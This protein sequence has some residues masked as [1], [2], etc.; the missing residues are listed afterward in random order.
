MLRES[1]SEKSAIW[2]SAKIASAWQRRHLAAKT[3]EL[4]SRRDSTPLNAASLFSSNA[5]SRMGL[6][7]RLQVTHR[8]SV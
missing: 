5:E 4:D 8:N 7:Q 2:P 3:F 1:R 6:P